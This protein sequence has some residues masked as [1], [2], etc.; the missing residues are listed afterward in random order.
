MHRHRR[1][2]QR[3]PLPRWQRL[4]VYL[5]GGALLIS[6]IAWLYLDTFVRIESDFGLEHSPWQH[7]WLILH[8]VLAMPILWLVGVL[9]TAHV[10]RGWLHR[11]NRSSGGFVL[12]MVA[13][14]AISAA[15]LYYLADEPWR[16]AASS[17]H[18]LL[19]LAMVIALPVHIWCGRKAAKALAKVTP[20][21]K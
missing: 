12:A 10:K 2:Q 13:L 17:V 21:P 18:W 7:R 11:Q 15:M 4:G 16:A 8:G 3:M 19:G 14:L 1:A 6:G 5:I 9:W 20:A